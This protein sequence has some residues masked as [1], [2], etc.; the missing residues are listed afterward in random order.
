M[1][2]LTILS[3]LLVLIPLYPAKTLTCKY[4]VLTRKE[5]RTLQAAEKEAYLTALLRLKKRPDNFYEEL[6][7]IHVFNNFY[8]HGNP[9]FLPWHRYFVVYLEQELQAEQPIAQPYWDWD[10]DSQHLE[11]A[12]IW[13]ADAFGRMQGTPG[14]GCVEDGVFGGRE[15]TFNFPEPSCL[16][17]L[18][19][20]N[21]ISVI[22]TRRLQD[23]IKN[24]K[25][26][27]SFWTTME[28]Q[29]HANLHIGI[30]GF[31]GKTHSPL[32]PVFFLHH[33]KIDKIWWEFQQLKP[34]LAREYSGS[35][36]PHSEGARVP[37]T[38]ND[39]LHPFDEWT[40]KDVF[41]AEDLCYTYPHTS[42]N[43]IT[44]SNVLG[45]TEMP[46][47]IRI[48]API[49]LEWIIANGLDVKKIRKDEAR[50]RELALKRI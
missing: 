30:G 10:L 50:T 17:R 25:S 9:I 7:R 13:S 19:K 2:I 42:L 12:E 18:D 34:K 40:V 43:D 29:P 21:K 47:R 33:A 41:V 6:G 28:G 44:R 39:I 4:G 20:N 37:A 24:A 16:K 5:W 23:A 31:M 26:F 3:T 22:D 27:E 11:K 32:D 8:I 14:T 15:V 45:G 1:K 49:P 38:V 35:Q 36:T 48:P 46:K